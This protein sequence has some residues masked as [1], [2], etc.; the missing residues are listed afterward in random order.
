MFTIIGADGKE[1]GP[2]TADKIREWI[3]AGRANAQTQVRRE[4]DAAWA[5]LGSLPEFAGAFAA[6]PPTAATAFAPPPDAPAERTAPVTAADL[7]ARAKP[8]SIGACIRSGIDAGK[9]HYF[10]F[11]GVSLLIGLCAGILGAIPFLGWIATLVLTGVFYGGLNFYTLQKSRHEP[12][13]IGVAFSGFGP[14]F[15]QL[16]LASIVVTLLSIVAFFC[17]ILPGIYVAVC[18]GF[19]YLLVREKGLPFW[20]AMEL[21][22]QVITRQWFSVFGLWLCVAG[23]SLALLAIPIGLMVFGG[24]SMEEN[25]AV[26]LPFFMLG[27]GSALL[28]GLAIIPFYQGIYVRAYEQLFNPERP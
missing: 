3:A 14:Q 28:V 2:V 16:A 7:L 24:L 6:T 18:W 17:L 13:D 8:F 9:A 23:I 22:R 5:P 4:G 21:G 11:L 25:T 26:G 15:G 27:I 1:Y 10:P 12:T 20:D 19:T